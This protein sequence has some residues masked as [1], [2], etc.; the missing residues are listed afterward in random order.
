MTPQVTRRALL[1]GALATAAF[2][3]GPSGNYGRRFVA[4]RFG[5]I[6]YLERGR[7]QLPA[8]V[9]LHGFPLNADQWGEAMQMLSADRRCLAPDFLGLGF[10]EVADGQAVGPVEQ[11]AMVLEFLDR[12]GVSGFDLVANDSGGAVAQLIVAKHP[13]RVRSVLLTNCD[14][15][16]DSPPPALLPVIELAKAGK[17]ADEWLAPW[18]A[19]KMLARS[20]KGIGGQCYVDPAHPT[21]RA[22]E[23]YLT[24]VL[25][26]KRRK[27]LIH[28]YA[29]GLEPNALAGIAPALRAYKGP[30]RIVWGTGDTIFSPASPG[31]LDRTFG[32]SRGVRLLQGRKLFWPEELPGVVA[33][34]ARNLWGKK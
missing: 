27:D 18:L 8:A 26:S 4:T 20:E 21:D 22:I 11:M 13:S 29:L 10:T 7:K 30:A 15:E 1:A 5:R 3:R 19:D 32:N 33:E 25:A 14:T 17:F 16:K 23:S 9:F 24:P 12:L 28:Q 34:E 2:G 6:A 31:E